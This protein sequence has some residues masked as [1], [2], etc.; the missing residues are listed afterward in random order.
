MRERETRVTIEAK[1]TAAQN[2][3]EAVK[4]RI[5]RLKQERKERAKRQVCR[6][7][8]LDLTPTHAGRPRVWCEDCKT[9]EPYKRWFRERYG[10]KLRT[11]QREYRREYR[12][13]QKALSDKMQYDAENL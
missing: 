8:G 3:L 7:C 1:L 10:E 12:K 5:A 4:Q 13:R 2:H 9:G 11:Y 6:G